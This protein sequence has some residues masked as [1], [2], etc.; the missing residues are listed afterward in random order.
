MLPGALGGECELALAAVHLHKNRLMFTQRPAQGGG[1]EAV[2]VRKWNEEELSSKSS[3]SK[4]I[5]ISDHMNHM[6]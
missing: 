3:K 1:G 5:F 4:V 2:P 6:T